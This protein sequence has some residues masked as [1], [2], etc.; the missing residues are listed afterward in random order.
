MVQ[1]EK[2]KNVV[3][4]LLLIIIVILLSLVLLLATGTI[5][6]KSKISDN[7]NNNQTTENNDNSNYD[8]YL[9][10]EVNNE[11][12][13]NY[14]HNMNTNNYYSYDKSYVIFVNNITIK[15]NSYIFRYA[16]DINN[17]SVKVY[18]NDNIVFEGNKSQDLLVDVCNYGNYIVYST[19]YEGSPYYRII[20]TDG[21]FLMSF[22]GKK[23]S[24]SDGMLNIEEINKNDPMNTD[25][26]ELIKYQLDMNSDNLQKLN[27]TKEKFECDLNGPGYDC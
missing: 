2:K 13:T 22:I 20:N 14:C 15:N 16:S 3:I 21:K 11:N 4:V 19:G 8:D 7:T 26:N 9:I 1:Q 27:I 23:V 6:F 18:L 25:D 17:N 5:S 12:K 24:Y 10:F